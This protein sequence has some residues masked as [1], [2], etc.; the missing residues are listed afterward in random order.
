M[1]SRIEA[2]RVAVI[3][4]QVNVRIALQDLFASSTGF[5]CIGAYASTQDA[6]KSI[7]G[8]L[9]HLAVID[10]PG[11]GPAA[12]ECVTKLKARPPYPKTMLLFGPPYETADYLRDAFQADVDGLIAK[13]IIVSEVLAT[14]QSVIE[15]GHAL[16]ASLIRRLPAFF[17]PPGI[18]I[19]LDSDP[20][21][22][23][24]N[25]IMALAALGL[26]DNQIADWLHLHVETIATRWRKLFDQH[27]VHTRAALLVL[28]LR[29]HIA[30]PTTQ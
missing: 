17:V 11:F 1:D 28:W 12:L 18:M 22:E 8:T 4:P 26:G 14:A 6:L 27:H 15:K 10:W 9:C 19:H 3:S 25:A 7:P 29:R 2:V 20:F 16:S 24:E 5:H 23:A 21:S 30:L 13:P